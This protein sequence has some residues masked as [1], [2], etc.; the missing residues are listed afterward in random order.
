[1]RTI[2]IIPGIPK[3][4]DL[5]KFPDSTIINETDTQPGTPVAREVYGDILTNLYKVLRLAGITANGNEDNELNGYQLVKAIQSLPNLFNDTEQILNLT[6]TVFSVNLDI[7]LLPSKYFLFARAAE[8]SV[9]SVVYTFKGTAVAPVYGFTPVMPFNSG[10]E[11]LL[12]LDPAGV[13][14]YNLTALANNGASEIFT[15]FGSPLAFND[16]SKL[17]YQSEGQLYSDVPEKFDLQ[18]AIQVLAGDGTILVYEMMIIT[19]YVVCL[20]LVGSTQTYRLYKFS[21]TDLATPSLMTIIG[22]SFPVG[23][24][25]KPYIYTN[26]QSLYISNNTGNNAN[27]NK[28][29]VFA[30][31]FG[32]NNITKTGSVTLDAGFQKTTNVVMVGTKLYTF[33]G[34]V[35]QQYDTIGGAVTYIASYPGFIGIVFTLNGSPYYTNG[36]VA[37]KWTLAA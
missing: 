9:S 37:K 12:I 22:A 21:L 3:E 6:G 29:D 16:G 4:T 35:L 17:Y 27:D 26:G 2:E 13:R 15:P 30:F 19:G 36:E 18:S 25:N 11:L 31:N 14:A 28:L 7:S 8:A 24:D 32:S 5:G 34:G 10:D 1:M 23:S 33:I 20:C